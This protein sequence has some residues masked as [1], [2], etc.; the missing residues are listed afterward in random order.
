[1]TRRASGP[2]RKT[3]KRLYGESL[4]HPYVYL[5][6]TVLLGVSILIVSSLPY[7]V[8]EKSPYPT[9]HELFDT[10][11]HFLAFIVFDFLLLSTVITL[12]E[13]KAAG[14]GV[15][16]GKTKGG[17]TS[18]KLALFVTVGIAWGALCE[19]VQLFDETRSFQ[20]MDLAANTV[21]AI[22]FYLAARFGLPLFRSRRFG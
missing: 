19:S 20:G 3:V 2:R 7:A 18:V 16:S 5:A 4:R 21:P 15:S 17:T 8:I 14:G 1:M 6:L 13:G 9:I 10:G 11:S 12:S 22:G